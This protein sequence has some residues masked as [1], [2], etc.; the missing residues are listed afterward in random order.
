MHVKH[1]LGGIK[2]AATAIGPMDRIG[3]TLGPRHALSPILMSDSHAQKTGQ[4]PAS[5]ECAPNIVD[6]SHHCRLGLSRR[7]IPTP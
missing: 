6:R 5:L 4:Y 7:G 1:R 3:T 2:S